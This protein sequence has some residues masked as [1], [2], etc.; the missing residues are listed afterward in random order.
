[1]STTLDEGSVLVGT[2]RGPGL[3]LAPVGTPLPTTTTETMESVDAAWKVVG[4]VSEDGPVLGNESS[5]EDL[6]AWQSVNPI[7]SMITQRTMTL[8]F[9]VVETTPDSLALYF[10]TTVPTGDWT[11]GFELGVPDSPT[12][13]QYSAVLDIQDGD[14]AA[15]KALRFVFERTQLSEGGE[16][17]VSRGALIGYPVTMKVLSSTN[18]KVLGGLPSIA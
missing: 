5:S 18:N 1:M 10:D 9:T 6:Y 8:G 11:A 16:I 15:G 13:Q 17:A 2:N 7:R 4:Y 12:V 3:W 14:D